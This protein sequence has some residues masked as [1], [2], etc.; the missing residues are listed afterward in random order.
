MRLEKNRPEEIGFICEFIKKNK[1]LIHVD[2]SHCGLSEL[3]MWFFG[4]TLR[5]AKSLRVIHLSGN[6]G[7]TTALIDFLHTRTHA[8]I[9]EKVN[10]IDF[11]A[12]PS[13]VALA[14][15]GDTFDAT[16]DEDTA[17]EHSTFSR[18][19]TPK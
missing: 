7:I 16:V 19:A 12:M 8:V 3:N 14:P 15:T 4:R 10:S 11:R 1:N 6:P 13:N 18:R 9:R 17:S 5:R 2:L